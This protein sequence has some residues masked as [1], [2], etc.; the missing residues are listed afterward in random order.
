MVHTAPAAT[1]ISAKPPTAY[2][3]AADIAQAQERQREAALIIGGKLIEFRVRQPLD[4]RCAKL[5]L[6]VR[7]NRFEHFDYIRMGRCL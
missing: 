5:V 3:A 6:V 4:E 1:D 7:V 2:A